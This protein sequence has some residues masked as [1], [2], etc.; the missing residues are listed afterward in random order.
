MWH[1]SHFCYISLGTSDPH[2]A[3]WNVSQSEAMYHRFVPSTPIARLPAL[4]TALLGMSQMSWET[5]ENSVKWE[6]PSVPVLAR[7]HLR[8]HCVFTTYGIIVLPPSKKTTK[9]LALLWETMYLH[10]LLE[11][12][13]A[14]YLDELQ[15]HLPSVRNINPLIATISRILAQYKQTWKQLHKHWLRE[16]S[17]CHTSRIGRSV[18]V[19]CNFFFGMSKQLTQ[20][21][22]D[23]CYLPQTKA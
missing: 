19:Q 7:I 6:T 13:P 3:C 23:N 4:L 2:Y 5:S 20:S 17:D 14:L 8:R 18:E 16:A 22:S 12:N 9:Y 11:A 10:A 15:T 21:N 1:L